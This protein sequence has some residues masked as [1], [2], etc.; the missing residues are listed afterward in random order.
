MGRVRSLGLSLVGT[1]IAALALSSCTA[2]S[3]TVTVAGSASGSA[4]GHAGGSLT[5]ADL[6]SVDVIVPA[7]TGWFAQVGCPSGSLRLQATGN[8]ATDQVRSIVHTNV[9]ADSEP[10]TVALI[11]CQY[12]EASAEQ[13]LVFDR[14]ADGTVVVLGEIAQGHIWSLKARS[15]G[16]VTIDISDMQAC[17]STSPL[18]EEH[19]TRG[20]AW[21]GSHI[22]QV[23]GPT[24]FLSHS[25]T[26][27]LSIT[28]VTATWGPSASGKRT[29]TISVKIKNSSTVRSGQLLVM[30]QEYAD[31][32]RP[33]ALKYAPGLAG[34]AS[35]T[36]K[37]TLVLDDDTPQGQSQVT[38]YE[39]GS[40][41]PDEEN[42]NE[43]FAKIPLW[44]GAPPPVN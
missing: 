12:G 26:V 28:S 39:L 8:P 30:G 34:G 16:G 5:V 11:S 18:M 41:Y 14:N 24:A 13:V 10:E 4:S 21:T 38:V 15:G 43:V 9:D 17:C 42:A 40:A 19:Q 32:T 44:S 3:P 22:T 36:V 33:A 37:L 35:T 7:W 20:Y 23:S 1:V 2:A 29:G 31:Q 6:S 27:K 25:G